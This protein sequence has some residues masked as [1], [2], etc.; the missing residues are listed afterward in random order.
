MIHCSNLTKDYKSFKKTGWLKLRRSKSAEV[1]R[2]VDNITFDIGAGEV[3]GYIGPNGAGKST[4]I[5]MMCGIL[6]PTSGELTVNGLVP[7]KNRQKNARQ[8][9]VIFGQKSQLWWDLPITSSLKLYQKMY[10]IP[11][12]VYHE[13]YMQLCDML[14]LDEFADRPVRTLSLGQR[15][16]GE[17]AAAVLHR[18]PVLILDEPTIGMDVVVKERIRAFLKELNRAYGTTILLTTHDMTDIEKVC[19]R[20]IMINK[21]RKLF[22]GTLEALRQNSRSDSRVTVRLEKAVPPALEARL[23]GLEKPEA[24]TYIFR[25]SHTDEENRLLSEVL[26]NNRVL[27]MYIA[28]PTLEEEVAR[29]LGKGDAQ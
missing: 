12:D 9:G 28:E 11:D 18:P 26:E 10:E 22:D 27:D 2:A 21:G 3:V 4:T 7:Y 13:R 16:R 17:L 5:K 25:L 1:F 14:E 6:T 19:A 20:A 24:G 23:R 29:Y 8:I 15:M